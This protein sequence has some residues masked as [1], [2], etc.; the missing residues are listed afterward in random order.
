[1]NFFKYKLMAPSGKIVKGITELSYMDVM[2]AMAYLERDGSIT[3]YVKRLGKIFTFFLNL[4][5]L[6][7]KIKIKI[8]EQAELLNN[9][10]I[11]LRS[12]V[13]LTTAL[14]EAGNG[15]NI[16]EV[17]R[18]IDAMVRSIQS[19]VTFSE[20]AEQYGYI[21]PKT[22][23][24]LIR[25][26]EETGML[27]KMLKDASEHLKRIQV[28]IS[29]TKQALLYPLFVLIAMGAG[30][31]FWFYFV[32]PK[33]IALF[34]EMDAKLPDITVLIMNTSY[35]VQN[36]FPGIITGIFGSFFAVFFARQ[37]SIKFKKATDALMLR[38]PVV[39]TILSA[40]ILAFITEY[41]SLLLN[42]GIDIIRISEILEK[43]MKNEIFKGKIRQIGDLLKN[44]ETIADS[45][46]LVE[47]FPPFVIRMVRV[48][49]VSGTLS[50]Q[51]NYLA[52]EYKARLSVTVAT[53]GKMIEPFFLIVAGLLFA[54]MI[55]GLL[56]PIYDII[57][58]IQ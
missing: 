5:S 44:G 50:E 58:S 1:M 28:I 25:I 30:F 47:I 53:L 9:L 41:A 18:D 14:E 52:E 2:S 35:F 45:V 32:V 42:G 43:S 40:S 19:G 13:S 23:I 29:D 56:L 48:G 49:E 8:P 39:K 36:N 3:I 33:I 55:G 7:F 24:Y 15:M 27:D 37:K 17:S 21:F 12:G 16:S 46:A 38:L 51:L 4:S 22:V 20:A 26:G 10:S 11:M 57:Q 34:R 54:I 31:L 6:S